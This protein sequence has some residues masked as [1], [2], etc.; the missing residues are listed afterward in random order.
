MPNKPVRAAAEGMPTEEIT[1]RTI[2]TGLGAAA[3]TSVTL[4]KAE[5]AGL[6]GAGGSATERESQMNMINH[7]EFNSADGAPSELAVTRMNRLAEELAYAMDDW[8]KDNDL[9]LW[10]AHVWP[11]SSGRGIYFK[12]QSPH[13]RRLESSPTKE[14]LALI[15]AHRSALTHFGDTVDAQDEVWCHQHGIKCTKAAQRRWEKAGRAEERA[16]VN[17]CSYAP[18]NDA[19][20]RAKASYLLKLHRRGGLFHEGFIEILLRSL[21]V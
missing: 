1:R 16:L 19:D 18:S 3:A 5:S 2:L 6:G 12:N 9:G 4:R 13:L 20:R 14:L 10:E 21:T 7:A 17:L 11:A 15:A 8:I